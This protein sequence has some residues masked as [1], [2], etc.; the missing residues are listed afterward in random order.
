MGAAF[1][2]WTAYWKGSDAQEKADYS[3]T[4]QGKLKTQV[5]YSVLSGLAT[6]IVYYFLGRL[7]NQ[8]G[9]AE[10]AAHAKACT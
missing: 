10:A 9:P 2:L 5:V 7:C 4:D 6:T 1:S 3:E 8:L